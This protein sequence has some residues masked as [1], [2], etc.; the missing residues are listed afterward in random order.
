MS[1]SQYPPS[2]QQPR[3][4]TNGASMLEFSRLGHEAQVAELRRM[5]GELRHDF[6]KFAAAQGFDIRKWDAS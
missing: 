4:L 3:P 1:A 5:L 6:H 2:A